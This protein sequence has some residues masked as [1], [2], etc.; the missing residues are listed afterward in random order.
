MTEK[1]RSLIIISFLIV[2]IL[3]QSLLAQIHHSN[4][5]LSPISVKCESSGIVIESYKCKKVPISTRDGKVSSL[6]IEAT[7]KKP[8]HE[9]IVR[10]A[11][12]VSSLW[13][14]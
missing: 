9:A 6:L 1:V 13:L 14:A 4:V 2:L 11:I 8:I 12:Y 10:C 5:Y 7:L 3:S